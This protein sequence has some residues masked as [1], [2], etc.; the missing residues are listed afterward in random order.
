[1]DEERP[2][3]VIVQCGGND[4]N[5]QGENGKPL[6]IEAIADDIIAIAQKARS[7]GTKEVF[8]GG[9]PMRASLAFRD[10]CNQLNNR[11]AALSVAHG[12]IFIDN[13]EL[14]GSHTYD[15]V[16]LDDTGTKILADNYLRALR[17]RLNGYVMEDT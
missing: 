3:V 8:I 4:I 16:H 5:T 1:M 15:G 14:L 9:V 11:L 17:I 6:T 7:S 10:G 12:Y 2:E 13:A